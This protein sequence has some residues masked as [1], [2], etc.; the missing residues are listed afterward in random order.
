MKSNRSV[1]PGKIFLPAAFVLALTGCSW[2]ADWDGGKQAAAPQPQ[3]QAKVMQTADATWMQPVDHRNPVERLVPAPDETML[4]TRAR[5]DN[6]EKQIAGMQNDLKMIMPA[7]TRLAGVQAADQSL[8]QVQPQAGA[9][10]IETAAP[11]P[12]EGSLSP[13]PLTPMEMPSAEKPGQPK[14]VQVAAVT[15]P[16]PSAPAAAVQPAP[17]SLGGQAGVTAS[18]IRFGAHPDK[19][20]IVIEVSG[21]A[22]FT[23]DIDNEKHILTVSMSGV[24]WAASGQGAVAASPLI[25]SYAAG[26]DGQGGTRLSI[27][28]NGAAKVLWAQSLPAVDGKGPRVV[29]DLAPV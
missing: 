25:A 16:P 23:Y 20:R 7:L 14:P 26:A 3:P 21:D 22:T 5:L 1:I 8:L 28:L 11:V 17:A 4:E 15:P 19:T 29:L 2:V 6:L 12:D 18:N 27:Q 10:E 13:V 24:N 9:S